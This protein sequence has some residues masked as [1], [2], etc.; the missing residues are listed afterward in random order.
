M[1][2]S[3]PTILGRIKFCFDGKPI[4]LNYQLNCNQD[5]LKKFLVPNIKGDEY[6]NPFRPK[7]NAFIGN[8]KG[9]KRDEFE[10]K[11]NPSFRKKGGHPLVWF[12]LNSTILSEN[13]INLKVEIHRTSQ[14]GPLTW[15]F[16]SLFFVLT[17][18]FFG[19]DDFENDLLIYLAII[20]F[21]LIFLFSISAAILSQI[22]YLNDHLIFPLEANSQ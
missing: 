10:L 2:S 6:A 16:S 18:A 3:L 5:E 19:S 21:F 1:P 22:D 8:V 13:S 20:G 15:L 7:S 9:R 11:S 12:Y 17:L 4:I 14:V